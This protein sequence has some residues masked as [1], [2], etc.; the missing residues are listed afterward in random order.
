MSLRRTLS[1]RKRAGPSAV[2][3]SR[4]TL[5][6]RASASRPT[7]AMPS[8]FV[9]TSRAMMM[10]SAGDGVMGGPFSPF[11]MSRASPRCRGRP[12]RRGRSHQ[13]S[14]SGDDADGGV[15]IDEIGRPDLDR[16]GAGDQELQGVRPGHDAAHADDRHLQARGHLVDHAQGDGLDGRAAQAAVHVPELGP[17]RLEVDGHGQEGVDERDRVRPGFL[18]R[19]GDLD[20]AGDVGRELGDE[21][22]AA[23]GLDPFHQVEGRPRREGRAGPF[24]LD[25]GAGDVELVGGDA[26]LPVQE[27]DDRGVLVVV[28]AADVDDDGRVEAAGASAG[29]WRRRPRRRRPAGRWR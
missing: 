18:G 3:S 5:N 22:T 9:G 1:L 20:D 7:R 29:P 19:L 4:P 24:L 13:R 25:V 27:L 23:R 16:R 12:R 2:K 28:R 14:I 26:L 11:R 15:G 6:V 8:S 17:A 21:G 10:R